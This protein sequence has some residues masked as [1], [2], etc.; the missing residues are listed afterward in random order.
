MNLLLSVAIF[1]L[2]NYEGDNVSNC[3]GKTINEVNE[4]LKPGFK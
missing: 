1:Y 2:K 4:K 3:S